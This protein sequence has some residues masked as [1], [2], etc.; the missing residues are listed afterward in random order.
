ML[1]RKNLA[2]NPYEVDVEHYIELGKGILT[3]KRA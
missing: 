1:G 2:G 3:C